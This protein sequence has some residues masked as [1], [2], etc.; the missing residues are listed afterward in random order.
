MF[1]SYARSVMCNYGATTK[2]Y[3]VRREL[4]NF[5]QT[6]EHY[7]DGT[8]HYDHYSNYRYYRQ[9]RRV[10]LGLV[11]PTTTK[12]PTWSASNQPE[13]VDIPANI[14]SYNPEQI[15]MF[16]DMTG[17]SHCRSVTAA[18]STAAAALTAAQ[19]HFTPARRGRYKSA[20]RLRR[21]QSPREQQKLAV[22]FHL[23]QGD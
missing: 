18:N 10:S 12:S 3:G 4:R 23:R 17:Y 13:E 6:T 16:W 21:V 20:N 1:L 8:L 7:V 15:L 9:L 2:N 11:K 19:R 5:G 22:K 14:S